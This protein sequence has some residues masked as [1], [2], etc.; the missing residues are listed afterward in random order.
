MGPL[1]GMAGD[2]DADIFSAMLV[3]PKTE[4]RVRKMAQG[5]DAAY[6]N[7]YVQHQMRL[8][9]MK[10]KAQQG[11]TTLLSVQKNMQAAAS[12]LGTVQ[13]WVPKLSIQMTRAR[14]AVLSHA[15]GAALADAQFLLEWMEQTP[16]SAKHLEAEGVLRGE[17]RTGLESI[18]EAMSAKKAGDLE[19]EVLRMFKDKGSIGWNLLQRD[20]G[21]TE[22]TDVQRITGINPGKKI[23]SFDL[24]AAARTITESMTLHE[25][26]GRRRV[27]DILAGRAKRPKVREMAQAVSRLGMD[28]GIFAG[29]S[30]STT[31]AVGFLGSAGHTIIKHHKPLGLGFM[32]A[33]AVGAALSSPVETIGPAAAYN[34]KAK[35]NYT[36]SGRRMKPEDLRPPEHAQ[37]QPSVPPMMSQ[38]TAR[39][40]PPGSGPMT[41]V[42]ARSA[43]PID[44]AE[45]ASRINNTTGSSRSL[46]LNIQDR[47]SA[48]DS[49]TLSNKLLG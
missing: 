31:A 14:Q 49:W 10:A 47:R 2:K 34:T 8:G 37:G 36:K 21:I 1:V 46:S 24:A 42:R 4:E 12:K 25:R 35:M 30:K 41:N 6:T 22:A 44:V 17:F 29:V 9:L 43:S 48:M 23:A 27:A 3:A 32:G 15:K 5:A 11:A 26:S 16:I 39:V 33:L 7:R 40:A 38:P 20:I 28:K 19:R 45:L 13:N 18:A